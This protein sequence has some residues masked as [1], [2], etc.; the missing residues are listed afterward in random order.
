MRD[1]KRIPEMLEL[2]GAVWKRYPD[3]RLGQLIVNH[4]PS[5]VRDPFFVEDDEL[6]VNLK[7]TWMDE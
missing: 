4:L 3:W 5:D 7:Q 1:P 6:L 2:L